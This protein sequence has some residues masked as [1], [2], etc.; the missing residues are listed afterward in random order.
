ME[1]TF[2]ALG[3]SATVVFFGDFTAFSSLVGFA[4]FAG[5][6]GF[7]LAAGLFLSVFLAVFF[8]EFAFSPWEGLTVEDLTVEDFAVEDLPVEA[9]AVEAFAVEA[10]ALEGFAFFLASDLS[11][12]G[13]REGAAGFLAGAV[14]LGEGGTGRLLGGEVGLKEEKSRESSGP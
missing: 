7:T 4:D 5:L 1:V 12:A 10:F 8:N 2:R 11:A 3:L 14:F 13:F 6:A 9:F